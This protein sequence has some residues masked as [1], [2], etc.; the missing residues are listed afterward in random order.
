MRSTNGDGNWVDNEQTIVIHRTP[1][2]NELPFA[3]MLYGI[4][5][6]LLMGGIV[7]VVRYIRSL[8]KELND[9]RLSTGE[10]IEY[11]TTKLQET[12]SKG[13]RNNKLETP[14]IDI[15]ESDD[16]LFRK[17]VNSFIENNI[18]N[19]DLSINDF[20]CGL[21]VSR[22]SLYLLMK[23]L[24]GCAPNSYL[25]QVRL[26]MAKNMLEAGH[27]NVSEIA[28]RCG[29]SDPKYFSRLFKKCMGMT[30]SE[31]MGK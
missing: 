25:Q 30:P 24:Y 5:M 8:K 2:F 13:Q 27:S 20:A 1:R 11:L 4:L 7:H 17:K 22:S 10:T 12:L 15:S 28:Y 16:E 26:E 23:R 18:S 31:Y 19:P 14:K 29:F 9:I 21:G 3:W 6:V